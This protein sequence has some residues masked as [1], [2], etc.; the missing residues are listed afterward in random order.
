MMKPCNLKWS[1]PVIKAANLSFYKSTKSQD[2]TKVVNML[3]SFYL[4][5]K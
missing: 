2:S 1:K 5:R 3:L 4:I